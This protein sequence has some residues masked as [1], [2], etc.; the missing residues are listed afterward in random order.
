[1][2]RIKPISIQ[3]APASTRPTLE[4]IQKKLGKVP[5]LMATL[6][7]SPAA[8]NSYVKQNEALATG[9]LGK[10]IG[11][12]LAIAIAH[13]SGCGYCASAHDVLG[14]MAG[15][16]EKERELNRKGRSGNPKTQ[17]ALDLA[18]SIVETR[19]YA[20]DEVFA[21]SKSAGLSEEEILEVVTI[22]S[23]NLFTNYMNHFLETQNDFPVVELEQ[24][25]AV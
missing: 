3:E 21:N 6:G 24:E 1:M 13:I 8:L 9:T 12:S 14:K 17:A 25:A 4:G 22:T 11:E 10:E 18:R 5:N 2:P 23:F 15:L 7:K 16:D 19:G 20:T